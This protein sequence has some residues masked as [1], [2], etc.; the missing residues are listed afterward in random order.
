MKGHSSNFDISQ[1]SQRWL[2]DL[3]WDYLDL[4]LT[5]DP[6]RGKGVF[7]RPGAAVSN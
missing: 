6:P 7:T 1:V 5:T 3:L 2:R 4:R